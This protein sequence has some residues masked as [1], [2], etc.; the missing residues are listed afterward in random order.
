MRPTNDSTMYGERMRQLE[1]ITPQ[2]VRDTARR[3][4]RPER[5]TIAAVGGTNKAALDA[6]KQSVKDVVASLE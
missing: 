5:L 4:F 3:Y 6:A 2:V 1:A